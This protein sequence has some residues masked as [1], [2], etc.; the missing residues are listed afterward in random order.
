ML[1]FSYSIDCLQNFLIKSDV[2]VDQTS[3]LP[4]PTYTLEPDICSLKCFAFKVL[5]FDVIIAGIFLS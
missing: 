1:I 3:D 2:F 5:K 4:I